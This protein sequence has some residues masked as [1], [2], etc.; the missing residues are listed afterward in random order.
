MNS[1]QQIVE[2]GYCIGCGACACATHGSIPVEMNA[3]GLYQAQGA[4]AARCEDDQVSLGIAACP[5]S[6]EGADEDDVGR[7]RFGAG[8]LPDSRIGYYHDLFIGHV[9]EDGY[10]A[11]GAS[12]GF[13]SWILAELLGTGA[14]DAVAHARK[15]DSPSDGVLFRY[16]LSRTVEAIKSGAKS[17]YYP[18]E[19][20]G[21]L[22]QIRRTPGRYAV[23]GLP[24]FIQAIRR[25]SGIDPVLKERIVHCIGL[26]CGHMKSKA[27]AD[28]L[29]WQIGIPPGRLDAIDFRVKLPD[30]TAGDYGVYLR[31]GGIEATRTR[32]DFLGARWGHNFFRYSACDFCD[33][34]FA[35]TA[36]LTIGDA[37]LPE[38]EN[39]SRGTNI[40]V[41]RDPSLS[42]LILRAMSQ[43]R[44]VCSRAE[45]DTIA[46]SQAG[47]LR[48]RRE[49][50]AYRLRLKELQ[51]VWAPR[52]RVRPDAAHLTSQRARIYAARSG[53]GA[54][55]HRLWQEALAQNDLAVFL[56]GMRSHV[57]T[58]Q[59]AYET[60]KG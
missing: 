7:H 3:C 1:L 13:G 52:K 29:G 40:V 28:C 34:V 37:W 57:E 18:V 19:M 11:E 36:D 59:K 58:I 8:C 20:S 53:A 17:C 23:V 5:F 38:H 15:V 31:G 51:G 21:V 47:G 12:G 24:C 44:V 6:G 35:E 49:G 27:F 25:L 33:N 30:R 16:S 55:S 2:G 32:R 48:D 10:R 42:T 43:G 46:E 14:I 54:A 60:D 56:D 4:A 26:V 39:D 45:P 9:A 41:V 22:E 50:L